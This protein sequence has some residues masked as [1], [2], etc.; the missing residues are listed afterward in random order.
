[1]NLISIRLTSSDKTINATRHFAR[2]FVGNQS[3][4]NTSVTSFIS[5][6]HL[7]RPPKLPQKN[8]S[9]PATRQI[10]DNG[11]HPRKETARHAKKAI[12]APRSIQYDSIRRAQC[13]NDKFVLMTPLPSPLSANS[14]RTVGRF[15]RT[16]G[17]R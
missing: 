5:S 8:I 3:I 14:R 9:I 1:M 4:Q 13:S 2:K 15:S 12:D 10:T 16:V 6:L 7:S 11:A 17:P